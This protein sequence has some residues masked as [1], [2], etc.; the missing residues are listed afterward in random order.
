MK[1]SEM[2][3]Q[4]TLLT[5]PGGAAGWIRPFL[6]PHLLRRLER[7]GRRP[8]FVERFWAALL[9]SD[10]SGFTA[11]TEKLKRLGRA[12]AEEIA[13]VVNH[14]FAPAIDAIEREGGSIVTFG[15][16]AIFSVFEGEA[17]VCRA[18]R[19]AGGIRDWFAEQ[20]QIETSQG[21]VH[22]GISQGIHVARVVGAHLGSDQQ[23]HY[24]LAGPG[25]AALLRQESAAGPG[26]VHLSRAAKKF[27]SAWEQGADRESAA[28]GSDAPRRGTPLE[29][30]EVAARWRVY[31]PSYISSLHE[32]YEGAYRRVAVL[33]LETKGWALGR[34][35]SFYLELSRQLQAHEGVLWKTDVSPSGVKWLC[36]FGIPTAHERDTERAARAALSLAP[37]KGLAWRGGLHEGVVAN[38]TIGSSSRRVLDVM[39]DVVN[40]AARVLG[41]AEWGTLLATEET[42]GK[43][44][45]IETTSL[46]ERHVKGKATPLTLHRLMS[47]GGFESRRIRVSFPLIGRE[48]EMALLG[49]ALR[50]GLEGRG[51]ALGIAG[52]AGLGKSRL[53]W[54]ASRMAREMGYEFHEGCSIPFGG[55]GYWAVR[56][57]LG[58]LLGLGDIASGRKR[59]VVLRRVREEAERLGLAA[60][61]RHH[62]AEILGFRYEGSPLQYLDGKAIRLNNMLGFR[63]H[64]RALGRGKPHLLVLEDLHWADE[65]TREAAASVVKGISETGVVLLL[66]Y[67][68]EYKPPPSVREV[69]LSEL[70]PA[71]VREMLASLLG[72]VTQELAEQVEERSGGNPFYVEEL[73]RHLLETGIVARTEKGYRV[74][75][76]MKAEDFPG[77]LESLITG[78]LD[79]LSKKARRIVELG[80]VIG[81]SFL[82]ELLPWLQEEAEAWQNALVEL[83]SK[84]LVFENAPE[85]Y[86][87]YIFKHAL[88]REVA[89]SGILL[90]RRRKL[91]RAVAEALDEKAAGAGEESFLAMRGLHWD[92]AGEAARA[93]PCYLAGARKAAERYT[94]EEAERL[95]RAYLALVKEPTPESIA[96]RNELGEKVLQITGRNTAALAEHEKAESETRTLGARALLAETLGRQAVACGVLGRTMEAE[97][98]HKQALAIAREVGDRPGE[99]I[100]LGNLARLHYEQGRLEAAAELYQ[101]A[102]AIARGVGDRRSEGRHLGN[103][104]ILYHEQGRF[105]GAAELYKQALLIVREVGDQRNEGRHLGNLAILHYE[106][107][108]F[109]A[110]TELY[111]QALV[112]VREVG[113]RR[114]EGTTFGNLA[115]LYHEQGRFEAAAELYQQALAIAREVGD[116]RSEG[117]TLANL[118]TLHN[119]QGRVKEAVDLYEQALAIAREL[120]D[121]RFEGIRLG[122]LANLYNLRGRTEEAE[123][124]AAR[125]ETL[126]SQVGAKLELARLLCTWGHIALSGGHTA[127]ALLSRTRSLAEELAIGPNSPLRKKLAMLQRVQSAFQRG[128]PLLC[129]HSPE[130]L[131][132]GQLR[133]L[134]RHRPEIAAAAGPTADS[135]TE[136]ALPRV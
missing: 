99:G 56:Q 16:D 130:D 77:S 121:R 68:P 37:P 101:Q 44:R 65:A 126:L 9:F 20:G 136:L 107:G 89:Y 29:R 24:L 113:D 92:K 75:R 120:G 66:L 14:C 110:A 94:H 51:S 35:Q 78:R 119:V 97:T 55:S 63:N 67:R 61:D 62:L 10:I 109:E 117:A 32:E 70:P 86:R 58:Q 48:R 76:R 72:G 112:I 104:A 11:L 4:P 106:R 17:S 21:P 49:E 85:P 134:R 45:G 90:S 8:P 23:R 93:K 129:G 57:L 69:T 1:P 102:L 125:G 22:V 47:A 127:Q 46:G 59:E 12:G 73:A 26:E 64:V 52:A 31:L 103:L 38:V 27:S 80:S 131:T 108:R 2:R 19:A 30:P 128:E 42:L 124:L 3:V 18:Q 105:E 82:A 43:L 39:G 100:H 84:E 95:Y 115:I 40:T 50:E 74:T 60:T 98:L 111:Q 13:V 54:E 25:I 116:R 6:P 28:P 96:A 41:Q 53:K 71:S 34:L 83:E 15:G 123:A 132:E 133:W 7:K 114:I 87:E 79:R 91:H 118:A 122:D 81:R 33:F 135:R 5:P 36:I 88:T